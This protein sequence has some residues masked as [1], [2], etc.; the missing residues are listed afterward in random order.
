MHHVERE[1]YISQELTDGRRFL[2]GRLAGCAQIDNHRKE[3]KD[4]GCII[5][6]IE[7]GAF[8]HTDKRYDEQSQNHRATYPE[9]S[10]DLHRPELAGQEQTG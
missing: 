8:A 1:G 6:T 3:E 7:Q 2:V 4:T 10:A 9:S 5:Q